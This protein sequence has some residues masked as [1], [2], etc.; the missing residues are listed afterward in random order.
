MILDTQNDVYTISLLIRESV[1]HFGFIF[2]TIGI[3]VF[4]VLLTILFVNLKFDKIDKKAN[5]KYLEK[6]IYAFIVDFSNDKVEYFKTSDIK[7]RFTLSINVFLSKFEAIDKIYVRNRLLSFLDVD[8]NKASHEAVMMTKIALFDNKTYNNFIF[9]INAI[10]GKKKRIYLDSRAVF[11]IPISASALSLRKPVYRLDEI[12]KIYDIGKLNRGVLLLI[13]IRRNDEN[14]VVYNDITVRAAILDSIYPSFAQINPYVFLVDGTELELGLIDQRNLNYSQATRFANQILDAANKSI[15]KNGWG[16]FFK[17]YISGGKF[18]A[19]KGGL[20]EKIRTLENYTKLNSE[21]GQS[22]ALLRAEVDEVESIEDSY[23][24]E[25][26]KVVENSS[27]DVTFS[28]IIHITNSR[29]TI[30]AFSHHMNIRDNVFKDYEDFYRLAKQYDMLKGVFALKARTI[31]NKF[32][33]QKPSTNVKLFFRLGVPEIPFLYSQYAHP[34]NL[35]DADVVL[36]FSNRELIDLEGNSEAIASINDL[37]AKGFELAINLKFND[38][39]LKEST[40]DKFDI[41]MFDVNQDDGKYVGRD[42]VKMHS[43]LEKFLKY[44]K[45]IIVYNVK[46]RNL[47]EILLKSG[48]SYISSSAIAQASVMLL[49]LDKRAQKKLLRMYLK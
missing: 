4:V 46:G 37:K 23:K 33:S 1:L 20:F 22:V 5:E 25:I 48:I 14:R 40:Y 24:S 19:L 12:K 18:I 16:D 41:F 6:G 8:L 27:V 11:N 10:D 2:G 26:A 43:L 3:V 30:Y 44:N 28:P 45:P 17:V 35:I 38:Y 36:T 29:A 32:I 49:P 47:V 21:N 9:Q 42:F 13:T 39:F 34:S 15:E 7:K 31:I